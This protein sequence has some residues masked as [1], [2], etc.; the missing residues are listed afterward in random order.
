[1][2]VLLADAS[3]LFCLEQGHLLE[4]VFNSKLQLSVPDL[5]YEHELKNFNG[6]HLVKMGLCIHDLD[7]RTLT[8][9]VNYRR[10]YSTLCLVE[11]F[12][13]A[14]AKMSSFVM[15]SSNPSLHQLA[16][17]EQ[18]DCHNLPWLLDRIVSEKVISFDSLYTRLIALLNTPCCC[19][20][21]YGIKEW[22]Q[23]ILKKE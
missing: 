19:L 2:R 22:I 14:L 21:H 23:Q 7:D 4:A 20:P 15:L 6:S 10:S 3:L 18:V 9:A 5:L 12:A 16:I 11:S 17:S 1:M 8:L 13:L